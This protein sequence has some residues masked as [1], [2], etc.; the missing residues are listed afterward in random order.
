MPQ[1]TAQTRP[2]TL[3]EW[4]DL[5]EDEPGELV[6]GRLV[7]DEDVGYLNEVVVAWLIRVLGTWLVARGGLV[8]ASDAR[9]G[10]SRTRGR[11][12]DLSVY[13]A[14]RLP[15]ARGLVTLPPDIMIE[16]VSPRPSDARRDRVEKMAEYEAFGVRYYWLVDPETRIFEIF[17][18]GAD[19]RYARAL[20]VSGGTIAAVP[21]CE[22]LSLDVDALWAEADR[23][24][25]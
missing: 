18:L 19:G 5:P 3:V 12:P 6:D 20:G 17:E 21:G 4:G 13:F 1:G 24:S 23:L 11:K 8:A 9:F 10:V 15:P 14:G 2:M 7:E 22:G 25:V 16:V